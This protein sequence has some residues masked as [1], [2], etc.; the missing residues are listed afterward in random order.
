MPQNHDQDNL[1]ND[2]PYM[3]QGYGT[4][5]TPMD[6]GAY[7]EGPEEPAEVQREHAVAVASQPSL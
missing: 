6:F 3:D 5:E 1:F 2:E 4:E 7:E